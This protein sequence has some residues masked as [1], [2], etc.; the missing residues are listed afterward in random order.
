MQELEKVE[1]T[2]I[3]YLV[4]EFALIYPV[5]I[6]PGT[7]SQQGHNKNRARETVTAS[8]SSRRPSTLTTP[9]PRDY[10]EACLPKLVLRFVKPHP[11]H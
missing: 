4:K 11:T 6:L 7:Q 8:S 2:Q 5:S 3:F 1:K 10:T 9:S